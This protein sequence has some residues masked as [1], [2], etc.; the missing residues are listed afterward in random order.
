MNLDFSN[1]DLNPDENDQIKNSTFIKL[2]EKEILGKC[3]VLNKTKFKSQY[4]D[5]GYN[6]ADVLLILKDG[7]NFNDAPT[8]FENIMITVMLNW[9]NSDGSLLNPE[10][11]DHEHFEITVPVNV[12]TSE[13][14]QVFNDWVIC[15]KNRNV[16][17]L[18][19]KIKESITEINRLTES[20]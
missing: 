17:E 10:Y 14:S 2:L 16:M 7:E 11:F 18:N 3:R 9:K 19:Q 6:E 1:P 15:E 13:S 20:N 5:F 12:L 4:Y 8:D